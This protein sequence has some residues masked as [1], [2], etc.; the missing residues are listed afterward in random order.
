[1]KAQTRKKTK[2]LRIRDP[3]KLCGYIWYHH[4]GPKR[5][6]EIFAIERRRLAAIRRGIAKRVAARRRATRRTT[7]RDRAE[8]CYELWYGRPGHERLEG[9]FDS[10][11]KVNARKRTLLGLEKSIG[12]Y[13]AHF[14]VVDCTKTRM[15]PERNRARGRPRSHSRVRVAPEHSYARCLKKQLKAGRPFE[16]AMRHCEILAPAYPSLDR[17]RSTIESRLGLGRRKP[18]KTSVKIC[19]KY[20]LSVAIGRRKKINLKYWRPSPRPRSKESKCL[21]YARHYTKS[22]REAFHICMAA[23]R[24]GVH[25]REILKE[26]KAPVTE[27]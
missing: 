9:R 16:R 8:P 15:L 18:R 10:M 19:R 21:S 17:I 4:T 3:F 13:G 2:K 7:Y 27:D 25:P 20:D 24:L 12:I 23:Q 5:K 1:V 26:H 22:W 14:A 6:K 11:D